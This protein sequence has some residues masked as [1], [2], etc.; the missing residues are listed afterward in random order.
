MKVRGV[1]PLILDFNLT[2]KTSASYRFQSYC[3]RFCGVKENG[4]EC[5][6]SLKGKTYFKDTQIQV[7]SS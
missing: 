4:K 3:E 6:G 1:L 5:V 7:V 2:H